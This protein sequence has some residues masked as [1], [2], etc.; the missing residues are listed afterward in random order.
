MSQQSIFSFAQ[1][2]RERDKELVKKLNDMGARHTQILRSAYAGQMAKID[3]AIQVARTLL[4]PDE[5]LI[6]CQDALFLERYVDRCVKNDLVFLDT[7]S[8]GLNPITDSIV[9]VSL[10]TPNDKDIALYVPLYHKDYTDVI[11]SGQLQKDVVAEQIMRLVTHK[12]GFHN[13]KYDIRVLHNQL[14]VP[15]FEPY[16]CTLLASFFLNESENHQLK[17]L[18]NKYCN[19]GDKDAKTFSELFSGIPFSYVPLDLATIYAGG[20]PKKTAQ[21]HDFQFPYLDLDNEKCQR[22]QFVDTANLMRQVEFPLSAVVAQ[23]EDTGVCIDAELA[24]P[25]RAQYQAH[26]DEIKHRLHKMAEGINLLDL[27]PNKREKLEY[28]INFSSPEQLK[29]LLYDAMTLRGPGNVDKAALE[30]IIERYPQHKDFL[31]LILEHRTAEKLMST[32]IEKMPNE[33]LSCT[34]RLH[35]G[36]NQ[37]GAATGRFSSSGPNLQNIPNKR[38]DKKIRK[39][40]KAAPGYLFVSGDFS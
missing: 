1:S 5:T 19:K 15:Y 37:Y 10:Y 23:M 24:E 16:W 27:P 18:W 6:C 40:F 28:P 33:V 14:G 8:N 4:K 3:R 39:M 2:T 9:G 26:I 31:G 13:A 32:Y 30:E 20:D 38:K 34:G 29:I 35:G 7:E 12:V 22:L 21:L 17:T 36:F 11:L 25:L